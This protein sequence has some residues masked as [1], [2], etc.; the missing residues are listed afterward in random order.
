MQSVQQV[1][2][3]QYVRLV[4]RDPLVAEVLSDTLIIGR[5]LSSS[6]YATVR[7]MALGK[8]WLVAEHLSGVSL[9]DS[10]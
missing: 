9:H 3:T 2:D 10:V 4:S 6:Q 1:R 8:T 7:A 5:G